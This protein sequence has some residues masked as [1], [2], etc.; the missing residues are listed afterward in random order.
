MDDKVQCPRCG[1]TRLHLL[2]K[3][4]SIDPFHGN[5]LANEIRARRGDAIYHCIFCRLQFYDPR[6]P[7]P[8]PPRPEPAPAPESA[9]EPPSAPPPQSSG[10]YLAA[11]LFIRGTV[12]AA[13]DIYVAGRVDGTL[14]S[15][16]HRV[17]IGRGARVTGK[18]CAPR[19]IVEDGAE[20]KAFV[21]PLI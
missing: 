16:Q 5:R 19:I 9:P 21:D 2:P 18:I 13:E 15:Q 4:D 11:A 17:T 1:T 8:K 3:P 10:T 12:E 14:I 7:E 6:Q 20:L